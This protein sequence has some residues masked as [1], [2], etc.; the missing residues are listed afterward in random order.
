MNSE[1]YP[2]V[3][4]A[5]GLAAALE[6]GAAKSDITITVTQNPEQNSGSVTISSDA[7]GRS[8]LE[9]FPRVESRAFQVIGRSA[10]VHIVTGVTEDLREIVAVGAAWG[11]GTAVPRMREAFPFL[12]FVP[13][14]EAHE[15]GP[16]AAVAAQ[17]EM[18]RDEASATPKFPEFAAVLEAAYAEPRLRSLFPFTSHWTVAFSSRTGRPYRCEVAIAPQYGGG[19]YLVLRYPNTGVHGQTATAAQAVA[20][21]LAHLPE[22]VGPATAGFDFLL[23]HE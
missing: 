7:P 1:F 16:A 6:E 8:P 23:D 10:G 4:K 22:S 5:G 21:A 18:L 9:V 17:W 13:V 12:Q 19:P 3:I 20:L 11:A 14:A 15:R 2:D